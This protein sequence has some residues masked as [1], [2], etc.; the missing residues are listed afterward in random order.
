ML[1]TYDINVH[2]KKL[3]KKQLIRLKYS[4]KDELVK[5]R[6]ESMK[7]KMNL[8]QRELI[9]SIYLKRLENDKFVARP[10]KIKRKKSQVINVSNEKR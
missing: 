2:L 4:R 1:K 8:Q 7:Q 10:V 5:I 3:G 9:K 6:G